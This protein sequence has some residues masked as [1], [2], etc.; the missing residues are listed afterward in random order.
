MK[1]TLYTK[2]S[3]LFLHLILK[4]FETFQHVL[5]VTGQVTESHLAQS[6]VGQNQSYVASEI[7]SHD[8]R[9]FIECINLKKSNIVSKSQGINS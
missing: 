3:N 2:Q 8:T 4:Q 7:N 5:R 6:H 1:S 9:N